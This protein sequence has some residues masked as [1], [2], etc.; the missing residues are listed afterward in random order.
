MLFRTWQ[1]MKRLAR[2]KMLEELEF[3]SQGLRTGK[4]K[5]EGEG[6]TEGEKGRKKKGRKEGGKKGGGGR[7]KRGRRKREKGSGSGVKR[8]GI[9]ICALFFFLFLFFPS[10]NPNHIPTNI[11]SV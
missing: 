7:D 11:T 2:H 10:F 1:N 8:G 9:P 4:R 5:K 3:K 6:K